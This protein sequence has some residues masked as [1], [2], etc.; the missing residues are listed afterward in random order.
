[1]IVYT[2]LHRANVHRYSLSVICIDIPRGNLGMHPGS[3]KRI[4]TIY[5]CYL[6]FQTNRVQA[7]LDNNI[8]LL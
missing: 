6:K 8:Q 1:M 5:P 3:V 7:Y 2:G 4:L